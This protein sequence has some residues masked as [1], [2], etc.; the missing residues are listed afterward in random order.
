MKGLYTA[1]EAR[2]LLGGIAGESLKRLVDDG[3]IRKVIPPGN[4]KRGMYSKEDVDKLAAI[5][6]EFI[7]IYSEEN[8]KGYEFRQAENDEE[9]ED[10]VQIA[11]QRFGERATSLEARLERFHRSPK[12]DYVLKHNNITVG[13]FSFQAIKSETAEELFRKKS[14]RW[15]TADDLEDIIPGIPLEILVSNIASKIGGDKHLEIE[16]GK[17]LT[18]EVM[19]LFVEL[20]K[21]GIKIKRIWAMSSTVSGIKLCRDILKFQDLGYINSEQL[22]FMLNVEEAS[23]PIAEQYHEAFKAHQETKV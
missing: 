7:E 10:S 23:V 1:S 17:R 8:N 18:M 3:K 4:R 2:R 11:K 12:G 20:G 16:Y 14:G 21:E 6:K 13:F 15:L 5:M 9:I 19:N 22:G